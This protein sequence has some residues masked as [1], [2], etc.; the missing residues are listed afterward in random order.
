MYKYK[1]IEI[2]NYTTVQLNN[3]RTIKLYNYID[4][5]LCTY[6]KM[7][8]IKLMKKP[9]EIY[10]ILDLRFFVHVTFILYS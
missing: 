9:Q 7:K 6:I 5:E 1:T 3:Y 10:K 4:I 8:T 2:C